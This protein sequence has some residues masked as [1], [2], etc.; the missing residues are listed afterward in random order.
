VSVLELSAINSGYGKKQVLRDVTL[1]V[2]EREF[3]AVIGPNGSGKSTLVQTILGFLKPWSGTIRFKGVDITN[4]PAA[5]TVQAGIGYC[6]TGGRVFP[7]LTV[8][9]NLRLGGFLL[10]D[11]ALLQR[12]IDR[13]QQMFPILKER[14]DQRAGTMSGGERQMLALARAL[15]LEPTLIMLDEPSMGLAPQ[16][17]SE[18]FD[19]LASLNREQGLTVLLVEQNARAAFAVSRRAIVMNLGEIALQADDLDLDRMHDDLARVY[20]S[21]MGRKL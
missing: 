8:S 2:A 9:E 14:S 6:P 21:S 18:M 15:M 3:I 1:S 5:R 20:M 12:R 7:D 17:L 16:P 10:R 4:L 19:T 13:A 11:S